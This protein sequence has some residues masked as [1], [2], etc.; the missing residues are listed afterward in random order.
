MAEYIGQLIKEVV[1]KKGLSAREFA[2]LIGCSEKHVYKIYKNIGIDTSMLRRISLKLGH[3][4]FY[5]IINN[6]LLSGGEDTASNEE[7]N[8]RIAVTEFVE[9]V[10][11]ILMNLGMD[12][13][14][15]FGKSLDY[16]KKYPIPDYMIDP[17]KIALTKGEFL[18][19]KIAKHTNIDEFGHFFNIQRITGENN[20]HIVAD[21]WQCRD[22]SIYLINVKLDRKT[23]DEW[24]RLFNIIIDYIYPRELLNTK[25][26][27]YRGVVETNTLVEIKL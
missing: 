27:S 11:D 19:D 3:D 16:D 2:D 1:N 17:Y 7:L 5:D 23:E 20:E 21:L 10:P 22:K 4:F 24:K 8:N 14:I 25:M 6:P 9:T 12:A 18:I 26:C 15:S 13:V